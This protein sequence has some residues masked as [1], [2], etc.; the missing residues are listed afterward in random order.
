METDELS[1]SDSGDEAEAREEER[2]RRA[3]E[4]IEQD[5]AEQREPEPEQEDTGPIGAGD[6]EVQEGECILSIA[7]AAGLFWETLWNHPDNADLKRERGSPHLLRPGDRL[8][9][10]ELTKKSESC[11][12]EEPSA[13]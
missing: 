11:A 10:P 5:E 1:T 3:P 6:H 4:S 7:E 8:T 12:T 13:P 2:E 9:V